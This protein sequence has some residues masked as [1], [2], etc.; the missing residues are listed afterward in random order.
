[1]RILVVSAAALA[2]MSVGFLTD[3]AEAGKKYDKKIERAAIA[4]VSA[5]LGSMRGAHEVNQPHSLYPPFEARSEE[6]GTL[7]ATPYERPEPKLNP[8]GVILTAFE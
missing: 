6:L 4:I 1:M 8:F 2:L 5:K 7:D 3:R